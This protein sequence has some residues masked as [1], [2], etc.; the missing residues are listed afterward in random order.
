MEE[1]KKYQYWMRCIPGIGN[2]KLVAVQKKRTDYPSV[3]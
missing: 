2:K 1:N 3:S